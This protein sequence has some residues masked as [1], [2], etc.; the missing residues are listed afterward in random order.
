M[1]V[2]LHERK[3][4]NKL[5]V[6]PPKTSNPGI[7]DELNMRICWCFDVH[8]LHRKTIQLYIPTV[9]YQGI[10]I[11]EVMHPVREEPKCK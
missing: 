7:G 6:E 5:V 4:K 8:F 9:S 1:G 2:H 3:V 11:M 10:T